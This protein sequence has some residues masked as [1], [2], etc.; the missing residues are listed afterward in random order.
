MYEFYFCVKRKGGDSMKIQKNERRSIIKSTSESK[1]QNNIKKEKSI[2]HI[3][4]CI[5]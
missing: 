3:I 2:C 5:T 1:K 4:K